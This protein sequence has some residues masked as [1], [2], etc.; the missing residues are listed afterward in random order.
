MAASSPAT[1]A[2]YGGVGGVFQFWKTTKV[3]YYI[4]GLWIV[5]W[6]GCKTSLRCLRYHD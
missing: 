3:Q 6:F 2:M 1:E 5:Q 4:L